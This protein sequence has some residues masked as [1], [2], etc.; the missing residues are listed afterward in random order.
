[1]KRSEL[2]VRVISASVLLCLIAIPVSSVHA[3]DE[4]AAA[5]SAATSKQAQK[6]QRKADR[7]SQRAKNNAE[8]SEL[9]K[10]GYKPAGNQTDYPQNL[11]NAQRKADAKKQGASAP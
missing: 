4:Q 11:Q 5:A 2:I 7:K 9:E 8:L 10:N 3:A 1:M 6:A